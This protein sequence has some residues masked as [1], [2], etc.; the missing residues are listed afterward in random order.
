[1]EWPSSS[2]TFLQSF[3][4]LTSLSA[5]LLTHIYI[6]LSSPG[7]LQWRVFSYPIP[8]TLC[9]DAQAG[10]IRIRLLSACPTKHSM[11][12]K[13][14]IRAKE[15]VVSV[16]VE[17][18]LISKTPNNKKKI[19]DGFPMST[20][21]GSANLFMRNLTVWTLLSQPPSLSFLY[22]PIYFGRLK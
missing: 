22:I 6:S 12:R 14:V 11:V 17:S 4:I 15:A 16:P 10:C 9:L 2:L 3:S 7:C 18:H 20:R 21:L 1:M 5:Y 19:L 8:Q 13:D